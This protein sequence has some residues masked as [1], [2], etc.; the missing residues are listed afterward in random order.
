METVGFFGKVP[1]VRDFVFHGLPLRV[2]EA[3]AGF[4]SAWLL[5]M[6]RNAGP[7]R[8]TQNMLRSPVWRFLLPDGIPGCGIAGAAGLMAGSI[9]GAGRAFPFC[10]LLATD[11]PGTP[12]LPD[13]ALDGLLDAIEPRMLG[14]MEAPHERSA[15]IA[16]LE[17]A[18]SRLPRQAA[19]ETQPQ[20]RAGEAAAIFLDTEPA[21]STTAAG[22]AF[23]L[24][25]AGSGQKAECHWWHDGLG[26]AGRPQYLVTQG[27][28][29]GTAAGPLFCPDWQQHWLPRARDGT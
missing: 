20:L 18:R 12:A 27:M 24:A 11:A 1:A 7:D 29:K 23:Y 16:A 19:A 8:G 10:V 28:P 5:E 22:E 3:W 14:F 9:D 6:R 26:K 15:L 25:S 4:V 2:T 17:A 21:W 13:A